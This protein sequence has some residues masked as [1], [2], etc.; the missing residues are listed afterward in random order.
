[1]PKCTASRKPLSDR[2]D[3]IMMPSSKRK[4][5][6]KWPYPPSSRHTP[7]TWF[8]YWPRATAHVLITARGHPDDGPDFDYRRALS[9]LLVATPARFPV[10]ENLEL[11][12]TWTT[13]F[14]PDDEGYDNEDHEILCGFV[15]KEVRIYCE[16][17][18]RWRDEMDEE[19]KKQERYENRGFV[20]DSTDDDMEEDDSEEDEGGEEHSDED[21]EEHEDE[22]GESD[23]DEEE[24]EK[25][26]ELRAILRKYELQLLAYHPSSSITT[27]QRD[28]AYSEITQACEREM[29]MKRE[30]IM[31]EEEDES[32]DEVDESEDEVDEGEEEDEEKG[33]NEEDKKNEEDEE[34]KQEILRAYLSMP[35][36][37]CLVT[38]I[39]G[40][41]G[42]ARSN[43]SYFKLIKEQAIQYQRWRDNKEEST[44]DEDKEEH[45]KIR[46]AH[47][48]EGIQEW[49]DLAMNDELTTDQKM[50]KYLRI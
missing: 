14:D 20:S 49:L 15:Q 2:N 24:E 29:L 11:D 9:H 44:D 5:N 13:Y 4:M 41:E 3:A 30:E 36:P 26:E 19:Q 37:K 33:E 1:M 12:I 25:N 16:A 10:L 43:A 17:W 28:Q 6:I 34:R 48:K 35:H 31:K 38:F 7:R 32:E 18:D 8:R 42:V 47:W 22:E 21:E 46:P 50:A 27:A 40:E 45:E 39:Y 23:E